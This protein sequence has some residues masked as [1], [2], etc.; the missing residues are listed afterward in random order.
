L[1]FEFSG[2]KNSQ[3]AAAN[4]MKFATHTLRDKLS[5]SDSSQFAILSF[6]SS[7]FLQKSKTSFDTAI[8]GAHVL[9]IHTAK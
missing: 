8:Q 3:L 5:K 1:I 4:G 6:F 9:D 2:L 7:L